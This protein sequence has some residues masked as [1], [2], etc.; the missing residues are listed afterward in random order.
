M[1]FSNVIFGAITIVTLIFTLF[2]S[3][4]DEARKMDP[5]RLV[6]ICVLIVCV[7]YW[8]YFAVQNFNLM[9]GLVKTKRHPRIIR[10]PRD[11]QLFTYLV[12]GNKCYHIPDPPTFNY[13]GSFLGFSWK[14]LEDIPTEDFKRK[15]IVSRQ[16][17]SIQT[18][19]PN[20][21]L[22]EKKE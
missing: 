18:F 6:V 3:S 7:L 2:P 11:P 10:D 22:A 15:F 4:L 9:K 19:F 13:L 8:I 1:N 5:Y 17:P 16:L 14:D 21:E 20:I 12:E